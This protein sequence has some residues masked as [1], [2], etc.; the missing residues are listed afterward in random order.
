MPTRVARYQWWTLAL[1]LGCAALTTPP[2]VD[3]VDGEVRLAVTRALVQG[4]IDV[5]LEAGAPYLTPEGRGGARYGIYA[6][7]Q[8][9]LLVPLELTGRLLTAP[10]TSSEPRRLLLTNAWVALSYALLINAALGVVV[11]QLLRRL[12]CAARSAAQG[13]VVCYLASPWVVWG[14]SLQEESLAALLLLGALWLGLALHRSDRPLRG[15]LVAGLLLGFLANVRYNAVFGAGAVALVV[16]ARVPAPAPRWRAALAL[17][18]GAAPGLAL[19]LLYNAL[20]FGSPLE[21]GYQA[22]A[23]ERD[24]AWRLQPERVASILGGLDYGLLWL[25]APLLLLPA[26]LWRGGSPQARTVRMLTALAASA[27]AI[28]VIYLSGHW[29]PPSGQVGYSGSRYLAHSLILLAPATWIAWR[30]LAATRPRWA[31]LG[32]CAFLLGG[33]CQMLALPLT[34][35]LEGLQDT[36]VLNTGATRRYPAPLLPRRVVNLTRMLAGDLAERSLPL[37]PELRGRVDPVLMEGLQVAA[38]PNFLPW[39]VAAGSRSRDLPRALQLGLG[40]VWGLVG[41]S[42]L[43]V[44]WRWWRLVSSA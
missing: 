36:V 5:P 19:A 44:A 14:R 11:F 26:L 22:H 17:G 41:L 3:Y 4:R 35:R 31:R 21:T 24:L 23:L 43:V 8:S 6:V 30:Q 27:L 38:R 28:Q 39:R 33:A 7:G 12:G 25:S 20:R 16:L 18:A 32:A 29:L 13:T 10:L 42:V 40:A 9:L 2:R 34:D 37:E 15:A 1:V